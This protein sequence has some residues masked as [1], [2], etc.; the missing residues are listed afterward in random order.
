[1]D[2]LKFLGLERTQ[3]RLRWALPVTEAIS[4]PGGFLYGGCG[5]AAAIA[6]LEAATDR[7]LVWASAQ[8]LSFA[9]PGELVDIEVTVPVSRRQVS[10]GRAIARV[11][12]REVLTVNAAL[13]HR[14]MDLAGTWETMPGVPAP[15]DCDALDLWHPNDTKSVSTR[16]EVRVAAGRGH[17]Q[18]PGPAIPTGRSA[19]WAKV[20]EIQELS[21]ASLAVLGDFLPFGI[22]QALGLQAGG[23]SLDNTLRIGQIVPTDWVL[24]DIRMHQLERG[25][26]HGTLFLWT[27]KGA[28]I[29]TASQSTIIRM[30]D[31]MPS[32]S[33]R[34]H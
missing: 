17:S 3:N 8:Y 1:M 18:L 9:R 13:G 26:G 22:S 27:E 5:L 19:L 23:N 33:T 31:E 7:P 30:W 2:A 24:L 32:M 16:L 34:E 10:Q 15:P 4:S 21:S 28:L 11:G 20:P 12:D 6:A 25:F 14:V 29:G